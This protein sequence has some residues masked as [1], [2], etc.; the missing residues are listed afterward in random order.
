MKYALRRILMLLVTMVIV[1]F[2]TFAA[3]E[4]VSGDPAQAMLGTEATQQQL[5]ALRKA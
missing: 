1:S 3:F 4:I 5:E 2:L